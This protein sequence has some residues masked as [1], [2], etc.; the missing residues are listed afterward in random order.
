L[1]NIVI[2]VSFFSLFNLSTMSFLIS[3]SLTYSEI[4]LFYPFG[5]APTIP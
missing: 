4:S 1:T 5:T 3:C 2:M